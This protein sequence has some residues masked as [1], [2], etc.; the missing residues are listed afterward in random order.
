M[1]ETENK[2]LFF[3]FLQKMMKQKMTFPS[4]EHHTTEKKQEC[5]SHG[6]GFALQ[7]Q[8]LYRNNLKILKLRQIFLNNPIKSANSSSQ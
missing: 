4:S 5:G 8:T 7:K 1:M 6:F 2:P 3:F